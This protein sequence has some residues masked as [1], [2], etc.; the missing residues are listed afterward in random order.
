MNTHVISLDNT[1]NASKQLK[2]I[3]VILGYGH[4]APVTFAGRIVFI[5]YALTS[6]PLN[7]L[8]LN[9]L[10]EA[11]VTCLN[12]FLKQAYSI[13]AKKKLIR[14][15]PELSALPVTQVLLAMLFLFLVTVASSAVLFMIAE[16]WS[17]FESVYFTVVSFTTVGLG[18][19]VPSKEK[20]THFNSSAVYKLLNLVVIIVG[21]FVTYIFMNLLAT[22]YKNFVHYV[23]SA[24][25]ISCVKI[26][27]PAKSASNS[28]RKYR[29]S[30]RSTLSSV[31]ME[32]NTMGS[33]AAI[34]R[35][36][37]RVRT[38]AVESESGINELK[39]VNT[40][41][42]ILQSEYRKVNLRQ[43]DSPQARWHRAAAKARLSAR[44]KYSN[45]YNSVLIEGNALNV[46][47]SPR[48]A[49][50]RCSASRHG[51]NQSQEKNTRIAIV[52]SGK[53]PNTSTPVVEN[54]S[55][56]ISKESITTITYDDIMKDQYKKRMKRCSTKS[57]YLPERDDLSERS[58]IHFNDCSSS[59]PSLRNEKLTEAYSN[60]DNLTIATRLYDADS[61]KVKRGDTLPSNTSHTTENHLARHSIPVHF[62]EYTNS[63]S[64]NDD[65]SKTKRKP[66]RT[67]SDSSAYFSSDIL[68]VTLDVPLKNEN[69]N[70]NITRS[71]TT[72]TADSEDN[73][74]TKAES[75]IFPSDHYKVTHI[76]DNKN[77]DRN[78]CRDRCDNNNSIEP[79]SIPDFENGH[80]VLKSRRYGC[81][82]SVEDSTKFF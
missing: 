31:G 10:L 39:A 2:C 69:N 6:I 15:R 1:S 3:F 80:E 49:P 19:F 72:T 79:T 20:S 28:V 56:M 61:Y 60:I 67:S 23:A 57:T 5:L 63:E 37:D 75:K 29:V 66:E 77:D 55:L 24:D 32:D 65:F 25:A 47:S 42:A 48:I 8:L 51:Q 81:A 52:N 38:K 46:Y 18:D 54:Q 36:I 64:E 40:I 11:S 41:E 68:P 62:Q 12:K 4:A 82:H 34:Q 43:G 70:P 14:K 35:A 74:L 27:E 53:L 44:R 26:Q 9:L 33:F 76:F 17:Y 71:S 45:V 59:V 7:M 13:L 16:G 50:S 58:S 22:F 78:R 21:S 30:R 73:L